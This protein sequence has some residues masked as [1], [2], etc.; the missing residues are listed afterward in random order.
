MKKYNVMTKVKLI[1][2]LLGV[3]FLFG[4][5]MPIGDMAVILGAEMFGG[6]VDFPQ[7]DAGDFS[8]MDCDDSF[9]NA[10]VL[11]PDEE[12][13]QG[14]APKIEGTD[15]KRIF[16]GTGTNQDL[17]GRVIVA[18][19]F[20]DDD[21]SAWNAKAIETYTAEQVMPSLSFLKEQ[22]QDWNIELDFEVW[23]FSTPLSDGFRL[24]YDGTVNPDLYNGG[25]TKDIMEQTGK[26]LG[27][28]DDMALWR[29]L[30]K[31]AD[32]AEIVPLFI[33]NKG[34]ITYTRNS[35][36][37]HVTTYCE[38]SVIFASD[39]DNGNYSIAQNILRLFGAESLY[40][41]TARYE[42][43]LEMCPFD[44]MVLET[45]YL[46]R[47]NIGDFTAYAIGWTEKMPT[48]CENEDWYRGQTSYEDYWD[49]V[50]KEN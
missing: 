39:G 11:P 40:S 18:L 19:F 21:E 28:E 50:A 14:Y 48:V 23:R 29:A 12:P 37:A 6:N 31:K 8:L 33:F 34:G 9:V 1:A 16:Y 25:S 35:Y 13:E 15:P 47:L 49:R 43:A 32:G 7:Y 17:R 30:R 24:Q 46:G 42:L 22:A 5:C 27:Y 41:P 38:H 36:T 45:R 26:L 20:V 10:D 4:G 3:L 2:M 44:I